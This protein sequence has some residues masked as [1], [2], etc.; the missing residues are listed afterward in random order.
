MYVCSLIKLLLREKRNIGAYLIRVL[1]DCLIISI[2]NFIPVTIFHYKKRIISIHWW[3]DNSLWDYN[4]Y[5]ILILKQLENEID[6]ECECK[7]MVENIFWS[8]KHS[9]AYSNYISAETI[10]FDKLLIVLKKLK[11]CTLADQATLMINWLLSARYKFNIRLILY[12]HIV[13]MS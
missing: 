12:L 10:A 8:Y 3:C 2:K 5:F 13:I 7:N 9:N 11:N 1:I 4:Y 6:N